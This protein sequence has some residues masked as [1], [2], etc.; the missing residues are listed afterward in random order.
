MTKIKELE[1]RIKGL[2]KRK[3]MAQFQRKTTTQ[4]VTAMEYDIEIDAI[5]RQLEVLRCDLHFERL[6]V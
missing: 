4:L 3:N 6:K 2:E 5:N 1:A